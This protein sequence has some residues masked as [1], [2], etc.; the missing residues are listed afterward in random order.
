MKYLIRFSRK[1]F[2]YPLTR[3]EIDRLERL[4]RRAYYLQNKI[5]MMPINYNIDNTRAELS[6]LCWAIEKISGKSFTTL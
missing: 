6:A 5:D 1:L 3:K 4:K 2:G